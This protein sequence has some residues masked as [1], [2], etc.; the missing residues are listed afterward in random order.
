MFERL[1]TGEAL[2]AV[3]M[4]QEVLQ[5]YEREVGAVLPDGSKS[6]V[7]LALTLLTAMFGEG[8]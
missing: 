7:A 2:A 8:G 6:G 5:Q 1:G 3:R 4:A